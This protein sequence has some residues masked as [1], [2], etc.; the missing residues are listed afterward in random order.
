MPERFW[1]EFCFR[2]GVVK[3]STSVTFSLES[4]V[5]ALELPL[6]VIEGEPATCQ[7]E[8]PSPSSLR[9]LLPP[10]SPVDLIP[11]PSVSTTCQELSPRKNDVELGVP[12]AE[13]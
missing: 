3:L 11:V 10:D 4:I 1:F 8:V 7:L 12:D 9:N 13:S 5:M 2:L 6:S